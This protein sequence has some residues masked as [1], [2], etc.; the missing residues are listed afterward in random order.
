MKKALNNVSLYLIT[1]PPQ[2]GIHYEE[3]VKEAILGGIKAVQLRSKELTSRELMRLAYR[4]RKITS[5]HKVT[6]IINDRIDIALACQAD[7]VHL[8]QEDVEID[9]I[10]NL[11]ND[12]II[13]ISTHT[14]KE[15]QEA[16]SKGADYIGVGP[17]FKTSEKK[18]LKPIGLDLIYKIK[19]KIK[20]PFFCI[21]GINLNNIKQVV[22]A[23]GERI[24][25]GSAIC[26]AHNVRE[27]T[28]K[29]KKALCNIKNKNVKIKM[30]D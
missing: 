19:E 18:D 3:M 13:G 4:L 23:G 29:I 12:K 25:I 11:M 7:G 30:T 17:I 22:D 24:A 2:R 5:K 9:Y 20:I 15:A 16:Q 14:F 10:R 28:R 21:G 6:F 27:A 26:R 1:C 8:G